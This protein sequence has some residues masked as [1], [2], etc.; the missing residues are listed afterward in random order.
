MSDETRPVSEEREPRRLGWPT[1]WIGGVTLIL[2]GGIFLL[3]NNRLIAFDNWWALFV[4]IPAVILA[5][6]AWSLYR[7]DGWGP[8]VI[9]PLVGALA[10]ATVAVLLLFDLD[11][12][13]LWPV[14]LIIA[15]I[16]GLI[17]VLM[18]GP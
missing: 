1:E 12:G 11:W 4:M 7:E 5:G 2:L 3:Q 6:T 10:T 14:F 9:G 16:A 8:Q 17:R 18:R 15:G 13:R